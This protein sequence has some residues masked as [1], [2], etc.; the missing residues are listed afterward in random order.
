MTLCGRCD[1]AAVQFLR[2]RR[3]NTPRNLCS[4]H[5]VEALDFYNVQVYKTEEERDA[6]VVR[7]ML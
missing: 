1:T 7:R 2:I 5:S 3:T 4:L 6:A